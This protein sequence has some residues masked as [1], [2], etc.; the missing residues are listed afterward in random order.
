LEE[1]FAVFGRDLAVIGDS[2]MI[3]SSVCSSAIDGDDEEDDEFWC[4]S[5]KK[6]NPK[7]SLIP[8]W[9]S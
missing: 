7:G 6:L 3:S 1:S 8:Y 2:F 9:N 5:E 4:E